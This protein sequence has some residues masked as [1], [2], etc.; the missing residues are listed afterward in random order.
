MYSFPKVHLLQGWSSGGGT[1]LVGDRDW[2]D[3]VGHRNISPSVSLFL[4]LLS[5]MSLS[6]PS[7]T[8]SCYYDALPNH[9]GPLPPKKPKNQPNNN[10]NPMDS[11]RNETKPYLSSFNLYLSKISSHR[12]KSHQHSHYLIWRSRRQRRKKKN[13]K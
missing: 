6:D 8:N 7:L 2:P 12:L 3:I 13:R 1:F 11:L 4:S 9:I 5:S 10:K